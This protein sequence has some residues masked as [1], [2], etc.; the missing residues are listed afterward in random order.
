MVVL[1]GYAAIALAALVWQAICVRRRSLS[2]GGLG[3]RLAAG[4]V[5]RWALLAA[6]AW[7]GWHLFVRGTV[8]FLGH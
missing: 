4:W 2:L 3:C 5:T 1:A 6:W 7:V 8:T